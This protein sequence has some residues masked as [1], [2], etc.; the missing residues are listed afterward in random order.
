MEADAYQP[1]HGRK[2][3]RITLHNG[4]QIGTQVKNT[5]D[6][7]AQNVSMSLCDHGVLVIEGNG[8]QTIVGMADILTIRLHD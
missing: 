1:M 6:E 7:I 4:V 2:V 8:N 3:K 5:I